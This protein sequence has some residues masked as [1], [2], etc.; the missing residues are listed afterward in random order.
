[1]RFVFNSSNASVSCFKKSRLQQC[2]IR[3]GV[4]SLAEINPLPAGNPP[5]FTNQTNAILLQLA[6]GVT[7]QTKEA[8][9]MNELITRQ[10]DHNIEKDEENKNRLKK[11]HPSVLKL[12]LFAL[13][14]DPSSVPLDVTDSCKKIIN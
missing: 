10:L 6:H 9:T 1:M 7:R 8:Q 2:I 13:A 12:I 11:L 14:K 4:P 5:S 3:G